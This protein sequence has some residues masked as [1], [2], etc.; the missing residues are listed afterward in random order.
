MHEHECRVRIA[1]LPRT[2]GV[3]GDRCHTSQSNVRWAARQAGM[4]DGPMPARRAAEAEGEM[5]AP[6]TRRIAVQWPGARKPVTTVNHR[7][8]PEAARD[9]DALPAKVRR[10]SGPSGTRRQCRETAVVSCGSSTGAGRLRCSAKPGSVTAPWDVDKR[11]SC[12]RI[13]E[14]KT[15]GQRADCGH[16]RRHPTDPAT[17]RRPS[18]AREDLGRAQIALSARILS[19][20][21]V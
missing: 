20:S 9:L 3:A 4:A 11:W 5:D 1:G 15:A 6:A 10:Q 12:L 17:H 2:G 19:L 7:M 21:A 16:L 8:P 18:V 14:Y 13:G